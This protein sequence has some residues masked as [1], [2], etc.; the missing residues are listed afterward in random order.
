MK[1][2][3]TYNL[4]IGVNAFLLL[5]WSMMACTEPSSPKKKGYYRLEF[6]KADYVSSTDSLPFTFSQS[7]QA[8]LTWQKNKPGEYFCDV[9]YPLIKARLYCTYHVITP[10]VFRN[11]AEES[12]KM[13]YQ[14]TAVATGIK[15]KAYANDLAHVYGI[16]YDIQGNVATPLQLALTDSTH[17]FFNASLYFNTVPN[18]D[19][20]APS[21][22]YIRKDIIRLMETFTVKSR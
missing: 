7:T 20:I 14:H 22:N 17:Y 12:R 5:L 9:D 11:F 8:V 10:R 21:L 1:S 13:A 16:L 4:F 19:S 3:L 6:P 15:E 18:A 2:R